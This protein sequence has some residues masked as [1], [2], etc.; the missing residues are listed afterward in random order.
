MK[1]PA[2]PRPFRPSALALLA[3]LA[4]SAGCRQRPLPEGDPGAVRML[5]Q[6]P[7]GIQCQMLDQVT[8][9]EGVG[10]GNMGGSKP[11][12]PEFLYYNLRQ[13]ARRASANVVVMRQPPRNESVEGCPSTGLVAEAELYHCNFDQ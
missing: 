9:R 11:A 1:L 12:V 6:L 3:L 7:A 13:Q 4:L 2:P 5:S 10:C 8:L